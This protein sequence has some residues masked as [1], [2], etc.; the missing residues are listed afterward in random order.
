MDSRRIRNFIAV[1]EAG[2]IARAAAAL[3]I[4]QPALSA[5]MKQME[6]AL[7]SELLSRSSKGIA[8]TAAGLELVRRGK[9]LL[10]MFDAVQSI[11]HDMAASPQGLVTVGLPASVA[12]VL[13]VPLMHALTGRYP[14]IEL[15]LLESTSADLGR[16]L[17]SGRLDIA[18]LF[19]DVLTAGMRHEALFDEDLFIVSA[20]GTTDEIPIARLRELPLVMPARPNSM[21][22]LLDKACGQ[23]GFMARVIAEISSPYTMLQLA[24]AGLS[25]TILPGTIV[26]R[27]LPANLRAM[28]IVT[29]RLTRTVCLATHAAT[30]LSARVSA[31]Q[32][33]VRQTLRDFVVA[34]RQGAVRLRA[35]RRGSTPAAALSGRARPLPPP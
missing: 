11:G 16:Q 34:E 24:Q 18:V 35:G 5:Q 28:R 10:Q 13:A 2:S 32:D 31:V 17:V 14:G 26:G 22:L 1:V 8:P 30:P 29:P 7:G 21:R 27:G 3:H 6:E 4:A 9:M 25:A 12:A 19:D 23:R 15:G 20:E 33:L